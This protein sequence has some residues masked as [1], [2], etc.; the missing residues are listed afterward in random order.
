MSKKMSRHAA[1]KWSPLAVAVGLMM[2]GAD[3]SATDYTWTCSSA[4]YWSTSTC[5]NPNGVPGTQA[6]DNAYLSGTSFGVA[7]DSTS[8]RS[9]SSLYLGYQSSTYAITLRQM[10]SS[11]STSGTMHVGYMGIGNL[12]QFYGADTV[13]TLIVANAAGSQGKYQLKGGSITVVNG[14]AIGASGTGTFI[15]SGGTHT[16]KVLSVGAY[17]N[18]NGTYTVSGTGATSAT[19]ILVGENGVGTYNQNGGTTTATGSLFA[20]YGSTGVGTVNLSSGTLNV[21]SRTYLGYVAG[22]QGTLNVTGGTFS[23]N[24]MTVGLQGTGAVTQSSG[25]M[26]LD[27][28][29]TGSGS[30]LIGYGAMGTYNMSGGTLATSYETVGD[31]SSGTFNQSGGVHTVT[32]GIMIGATDKGSGTYTVS[33]GN[34]TAATITN[35]GTLTLSGG[36]IDAVVTNNGVFNYNGGGFYGRLINNGYTN[37]NADAVLADGLDN[38]SSL[39]VASNRSLTISGTARSVNNGSI[40]LGGGLLV[41]AAGLTNEGSITGFGTIGGGANASFINNAQLLVN[42]GNLALTNAGGNT[43]AG[44]LALSSGRQLQLT[45]SSV[46]LT[47]TGTTDLAGGQ[48]TG[49]GSLVNA[50]GGSIIGKGTIASNFSNA[51]YL[52]VGSGTTSITRDFNNSGLI[53]LNASSANLTGG[54]I[55]NSGTVQGWGNVANQVANSGTIEASGG[56]LALSHA[57]S[58]N[59]GTIATGIGSKVLFTNGLPTN[60]GLILLTGGTFDNG[61]KVLA[62]ASGTIGTTRPRGVISGN[63][64]LRTGGLTNGGDISLSFGNSNVTGAI[65]N[66]AGGTVVVSNGAQVTF[67]NDLKNNGELRVSEGGAANFFGKV[68]G[69]G[70]FSGDGQ[71]RFEGGFNPGNSPAVVSIGFKSTYSSSS[72]IEMELGGTTPG[73]CDTCSDKIIFNNNVTLKGGDLRVVWW[74]SNTGSDGQ[75][76]D[77]FDWNGPLTGT[78]GHLY[79]PTLMSGLGWDSSQLYTTGELSIHAVPEPE[80]YALMLAG[81]LTVG[82][83]AMRRSGRQRAQPLT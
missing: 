42:N 58:T 55:A 74:G 62:N 33:N 46:T 51:G 16:D 34:L 45:S 36:W 10:G 61:G 24:G 59:T 53:D 19:S 48:I 44:T 25:T 29:G 41:Q 1:L 13:G 70:T 63:G 60:E 38:N 21:N 72:W 22:A 78:F 26:R 71:S 39:F 6:G 37:L 47:N 52:G 64:N 77:L 2:A 9:F 14:S 81:L 76:Y 68:S 65:T 20:G 69:A 18:S 35:N 15:N 50:A 56:T 40:N 83:L 8:D 73:N 28:T 75:V 80:S 57:G 54:K 66:N 5:W 7:V 12:D 67:N 3:A 32:N 4:G 43:N 11:L 23:G 27:A 31:G 49:A 79:L 17:S 30:L 82:N